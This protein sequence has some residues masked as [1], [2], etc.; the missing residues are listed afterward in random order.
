[1]L[2]FRFT[3]TY[4]VLLSSADDNP[5]G[6]SG[7]ATREHQHKAAKDSAESVYNQL[8]TVE[9]L[10]HIVPT[11]NGS[12]AVVNTISALAA[13]ADMAVPLVFVGDSKVTDN[14]GAIVTR[15][16]MPAVIVNQALID[17]GTDIIK[18]AVAHELGHI[19]MAH[20]DPRL[21]SS[22]I[23]AQRNDPVVSRN[24]ESAA[25]AFA[26]GLGQGQNLISA[27]K[28]LGPDNPMDTGHPLVSQR[29]QDIVKW[30]NI[31]CSNALPCT[32]A[33]FE[34]KSPAAVPSDNSPASGLKR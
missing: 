23:A 11:Y 7:S 27:L 18:G 21:H 33:G 16:G 4:W 22:I 2:S 8:P 1:V 3:L 5:S 10:N 14:A 6:Q 30:A 9:R 28:F 26:V 25:D 13:Q 15:D 24:F 20:G 19:A 12:A 31:S 32:E 29:V 17:Q 34:A